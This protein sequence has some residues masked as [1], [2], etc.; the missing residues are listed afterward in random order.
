MPAAQATNLFGFDRQDLEAYFDAAGHRPFRARQVM[1]WAY[2]RGCLDFAAMTDLAKSLRAWLDGNAHF[3]PPTVAR[4]QD[5]QDGVVKWAIEVGGGGDCVET[6]LIPERGRNTLCVSSQVGCMLD[7]AF[8]AT[9]KQG[10]N[11]NL[12]TAEIIGQVWLANEALR[13]R[14]ECVTNVVLMGMGEPLLNF[15]AVLGAVNLMMDDLAFG[16]SRRRVTISTAGVAPAIHRLAEEVTGVSLAVSLHAPTDALRDELVP[17][18]RKYPLA[19]LLAACRHYLSGLGR[20][21]ALTM[22]YTLLKGVNDSPAQARQLARLL[23]GLRCKINLI[24][25]NPFPG[26]D[27]ARPAPQAVRGFQTTLLNAGYA[28]MLRTTR[29]DSIDAACGQLVGSVADRTRRQARYQARLLQTGGQAAPIAV[30]SADTPRQTAPQ[31][32]PG[33]LLA[34]G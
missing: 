13:Q 18:N 23:A 11:G 25:F 27:F 7:C 20:R 31:A 15:E 6:V 29:G 10:F 2:Q 5:A 8:C 21:R 12:A 22:E 26:A 34:A 1:K 17:L 4:R 14:G 30:G 32:L 19:D 3:T 16:I 28:A 24:P 9:G 33:R